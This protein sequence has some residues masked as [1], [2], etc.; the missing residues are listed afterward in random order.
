[1]KGAFNMSKKNLKNFHLGV[2]EELFKVYDDMH[3]INPVGKGKFILTSQRLIFS[4][5]VRGQ[6]GAITVES[7]LKDV[8]G[9]IKAGYSK[10]VNKAA[11]VFGSLFLILGFLV[12]AFGVGIYLNVLT[13]ILAMIPFV[14]TINFSPFAIYIIAGGGA[15][16]VIGLLILIIKSNIFYLEILSKSQSNEFLK[17]STKDKKSKDVISQ[18]FVNPDKNL[19]ELVLNLGTDILNA[20]QFTGGKQIDIS[21]LDE[22]LDLFGDPKKKRKKKKKEKKEKEKI[23][24]LDE[25]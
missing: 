16:F 9:G 11:K 12:A 10:S 4:G 20:Q 24:L 17:F 8:N 25:E 5:N 13:Q 21:Q 15:A 23:S 3:L 2:N 1:M 22:E 6:R 14:N 7:S 19:K 18:I